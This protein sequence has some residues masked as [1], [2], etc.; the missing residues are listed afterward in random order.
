MTKE[1]F[2]DSV[3]TP[4]PFLHAIEVDPQNHG[5]YSTTLVLK[6]SDENNPKYSAFQTGVT[7]AQV[8]SNIAQ[9]L[10]GNLLEINFCSRTGNYIPPLIEEPIESTQMMINHVILSFQDK[11]SRMLDEIQNLR[12]QKTKALEREEMLN[13]QLE[14]AK[15]E[16][17]VSK[18]AQ[19]YS[20]AL[21]KQV[22]GQNSNLI[23]DAASIL[24]P[25]QNAEINKALTDEQNSLLLNRLR[26]AQQER[27]NTLSPERIHDIEEAAIEKFERGMN[28]GK[29]KQ[30]KSEGGGGGLE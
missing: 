20:Q 9:Q 17:T 8:A 7:F 2:N 13:Q 4:Y 22:R 12:H 23:K 27:A 11:E 15:T 19:D 3:G 14:A 25:A 10:S 28:V 24:V 21:V 29:E 5:S 16:V 1:T 18:T 30:V 6:T 26:E